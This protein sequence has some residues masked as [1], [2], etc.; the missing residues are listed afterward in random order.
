MAGAYKGLTVEIGA[1][2]SKF[3]QAL[4]NI[5]R[6]AKGLKDNLK[7]VEKAAKL[8]P[9]NTK[10]AEHAMEAYQDSID[11]AEERL[12]K[13]NKAEEELAAEGKKLN[14]EGWR[15]LQAEIAETEADIKRLREEMRRFEQEQAVAGS[16]LG[17]VGGFLSEHGETFSKVGGGMQAVGGLMTRTVTPA[18]TAAGAAS[19]KAAVDIDTALTGVR[20]TVDATEEEYQA[21]KESAIEYS[22]VNAVNATDVLNAEELG[23]QLGVAKE[24]LEDFAKVTTS[25][26]IAT[27]M[28]VDQASTNMAQFMNVTVATADKTKTAAEQY[29]AYGNVIVGLGNNLA[30]TESEI[31]DFALR[32]ASAGSQAGMSQ[33]DI[34]GIG[35]ALASLGL[36]AQAGGTA[37]SQTI[38]EIGLAVDRG[39]EEL[40]GFAKVA[41]TSAEEFAA[42]WKTDATGAFIDFINGLAAGN[43]AGESMNLVLDELGITGIRQSDA[44]RRLAGNTEL[45]AGAVKLAND[46]W[47]DGT[48]LSDEV[49]NKNDSLAARFQM[50][51]NRLVA[52]AE[53]VGEPLAEALLE[54]L[55]AAE[56]LFEAI[57][58]GAKK[59]ANMSKEEQ[60]TVLKALALAAALG[61]VLTVT[62]KLVSQLGP[63]GNG[64]KSV[65]GFFARVDSI[66]RGAGAAMGEVAAGAGA[67]GSAAGAAEKNISKLSVGMGALKAGAVAAAIAGVLILVDAIA[68]YLEKQRQFEAATDGMVEAASSIPTAAEVASAAL[69]D[70]ADAAENAGRKLG[71]YKKA[72]EEAAEEGA[73]F[74]E[75]LGE[76]FEEA[77]TDAGLAQMYSDRIL[78]LAGNCNGSATKVAELKDAIEKY[79]EITGS[80]YAITDEF[81]G[82][83]NASTEELKANTDAAMENAYAKA[84][85]EMATESAKRE[86]EIDMQLKQQKEELAAAE[87]DLAEK[88]EAAMDAR[89]KSAGQAMADQQ[90]YADAQAK[91]DALKDSNVSL[92]E[93]LASQ[94]ETTEKL[95]GKEAEYSAAADEAAKK[96]REAA[97]TAEDYQKA[98]E[99]A[100]GSA[101]SFAEAAGSIGMETEDFA[102][103]LK[104]AGISASEFAALGADGFKR[105]YDEA[106]GDIA[107]V[108]KAVNAMN[109]LGIDPK[110]LHIEDDGSLQDAKGNVIDLDSRTIN[111]KHFEV[112]DDGTIAS[113]ELMAEG[114]DEITIGEK[115]FEV[116]DG[117]TS[118]QAKQEALKAFKTVQ[119]ALSKP[120][121]LKARDRTKPAVSS[122]K[123]GRDSIKDKSFNIT[124]RDKSTSTIR[125]IK[126]LLSGLRDKVVKVTT[127]KE[128]VENAAGG[129]FMGNPNI[130]GNIPRHAD[131]GILARPTLTSVGLVGE[132]G[133]EAIIPLTNS[134]YYRPLSDDITGNVLRGMRAAGMG[135]VT[136]NM[137][138]EQRP[139]EDGVAFSRRVTRE[140]ELGRA[141]G[142]F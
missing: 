17:K 9:G 3:H 133:A 68:D 22:K 120:V 49:A 25:L 81:S 118:E 62:G 26:D 78:E 47:R 48:A 23:G 75:K 123:K 117:G 42:K 86:I 36:E 130:L 15:A 116:S 60:Q 58:N 93:Q 8:D 138:V 101:E 46:Q 95:I 119:N 142:E 76:A 20:K 57:E 24:N 67:A 112:T 71:S 105:F 32:M 79:N 73:K 6:D 115:T 113:A 70:Q 98:L 7:K 140:L 129:V 122:A 114:L 132:A 139:G 44:M 104:E 61:P 82:A 10:L 92:E 94:H 74:T 14:P 124:A 102:S 85:S 121:D 41:G 135:G 89:G 27:N 11:K 108:T 64:L 28:N 50:L 21:L 33:A 54:A 131:G 90:A 45:L 77:G 88:R 56:P 100:G 63:L 137:H 19:L 53:E 55:D 110:E 128:T 16:A 30:T 106:G 83:I 136:V 31:S 134:R 91:V 1:N 18:I 59:F 4:K 43:E 103:Q 111:G 109:D 65:A 87:A 80:S 5:D 39:G 38:T 127:K 37:F 2:T 72:A 126:D 40:E 107:G 84:A 12:K 51:K 13:L 97:E 35:G 29:E 66:G 34:L 52:V 99:G 96:A 69:D 125:G 141:R